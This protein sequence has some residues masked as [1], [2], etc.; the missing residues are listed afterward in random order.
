MLSFAPIQTRLQERSS[1]VLPMIWQ[2]LKTMGF[3]LCASLAHATAVTAT[4][5]GFP[6]SVV[7][8]SQVAKTSTPSPSIPF[9]KSQAMSWK[10]EYVGR[11]QMD[12]PTN[13]T[14][15]WSNEFDMAVVKRLYEM[16]PETFWQ[17]VEVVRKRYENQKHRKYSSR[18][19]HYEK[20]GGNAAFVIFYD[21]EVSLAAAN[22]DRYVHLD[23]T[24]AY[25]F[26]GVLP[27]DSTDQPSP[28]L[29]K[30]FVA[31]YTPIFS[32]IHPLK[33]GQAPNRDG[34]AIDG[35]VVS[36]D[37]GRNAVTG[38]IVEIATGAYLSM[39]YLE[40]NYQVKLS[41][42][43]EELAMDEEYAKQ[44]LAYAE[45][46]GV[47]EFKVLRR[48]ERTLVGIA[49]QEFIAKTTLKNGH[50]YYRFNWQVKGAND[51]GLLEP[52]I[53][54]N[55]NTPKY[56]TAHAGNPPFAELPP[57]PE[58]IKLWEFALASFK[59]RNGALPDGQQIKAVN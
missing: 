55:L 53:A 7:S 11:V 30:P 2:V 49:G 33:E 19:A 58:L 29:F 21:N 42:S 44:R 54:I 26:K 8:P 12:F 45:P 22:L 35:A 25:Q 52:T 24:H 36:G 3:F 23:E 18:L 13:R 16:T 37:T 46:R 59:W 15:N 31:Q 41:N 50:S 4:E 9:E 40:N 17:G 48:Q 51:G 34:L 39:A 38:L 57:E 32:R 5:E 10:T 20:V 1:K 6:T 14:R 27:T 56:P 28:S 47:R 43:F